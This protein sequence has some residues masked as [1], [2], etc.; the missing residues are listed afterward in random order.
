VTRD[1]TVDSEVLAN[2]LTGDMMHDALRADVLAVLLSETPAE[3]A[4]HRARSTSTARRS[5]RCRTRTPT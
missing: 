4:E 1:V 2:H 3:V 5:S